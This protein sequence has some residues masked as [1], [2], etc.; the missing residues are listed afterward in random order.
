LLTLETYTTMM[1]ANL[2]QYNQQ[3]NDKL[4]LFL[5]DQLGKN[6]LNKTALCEEMGISTSVLYK[7]LS[8]HSQFTLGE[9][10][11]LMRKYQISFDSWIWQSHEKV[12]VILPGMRQPVAS[13]ED[14]LGRLEGLF[15]QIRQVE[16]PAIRYATREM[17]IFYYFIQPH[18]GAFKMYFFAKFIWKIPGLSE[19]VPF[20]MELISM[21]IRKQMQ[22][23]WQQYAKIPSSEI[24]NPNVWDNTL[25]QILYLLERREFANPATSL[26]ILESVKMVVD[27]CAY[28]ASI[29]FK[30][31]DINHAGGEVHY[32]NNRVTHTNNIIVAGN[33]DLKWLFIT[34]D[35]PNYMITQNASMINYTLRWMDL[36]KEHAEPIENEE[37]SGGFF[38][39]LHNK[40]EL[41]MNKAEGLISRDKEWI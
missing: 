30:T 41:A 38:R 2:E 20:S 17:P 37:D 6:A 39:S 23:L 22:G 19:N 13:I 7:R 36:L 11:F 8:G 12:E 33:E 5:K 1:Q 40:V 16:N 10:G 15:T 27:Q 26:D 31:Y 18:L 3:L 28:M 25:Q 24:W 35:N 29:G 32:Y 9:L 14:F 34:H 4:I 21:Y